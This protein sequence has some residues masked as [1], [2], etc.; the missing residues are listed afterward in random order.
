M[1]S[2]GMIKIRVGKPENH[3]IILTDNSKTKIVI[4]SEVFN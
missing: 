3:F 4:Y 1:D 2:Y